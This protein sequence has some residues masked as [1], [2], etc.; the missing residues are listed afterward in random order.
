MGHPRLRMNHTHLPELLAPAGDWER[1]RTAVAYGADAV[2]LGGSGLDLRAQSKGFALNEVAAAT[3]LA[4]AAGAKVYYCL[5][6][7]ARQRHLPQI[8]AA[9]DT[10]A[11]VPL[12]GLIVADP[13]VLALARRR[14]PHLPLHLSTQANT[15]NAASMAFWLENGVTRV[16]LARELSC[17]ELRRIRQAAP[18]M[19]LESFVHGAQCMAISGRCLLSDYLN[20]RSAN[21]G[22]CTHPCRFDYRT[23][24][25][26]E[27][28]RQGE[29]CWEIEPHPEFSPIFAADDLC[30][31]PYLA[32]FV[33][34][35]WQSLKIEGRI[36]TCSYLGQVV[37]VYRTALN[38]LAQG[39]FRRAL[40]LRELANS[41]T[42]PLSSGFF[43]PRHR[44]MPL[45]QP[46]S[47]R[48]AIVARIEGPIQPGA[49][50]ISAR[51]RFTE[52]EAIEILLPG[53]KRPALGSFALEKPDGSRL[54]TIHSGQRGILR[55]EHPDLAPDLL[56]RAASLCGETPGLLT[57]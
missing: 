53:L 33:H 9:L 5:N 36:K 35:G 49:W 48:A 25:V 37:D 51:H 20:K 18:D 3:Q 44:G 45:A 1:L 32:W 14:A 23:Y 11:S 57:P 8:E 28:A 54:E 13:G 39:R 38:D 55:S 42:R 7:L 40:Y 6:I 50:A 10:L 31:A 30:L 43:L 4:T 22:A 27:A 52:T 19:E 46:A 47:P 26:E 21:L 29:P 24:T 15:S 34:Q 2:Y 12:H 16:N 41:A 17:H 56:L